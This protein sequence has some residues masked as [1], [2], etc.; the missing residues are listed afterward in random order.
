MRRVPRPA[1]PVPEAVSQHEGRPSGV[2]RH[3]ARPARAAGREEGV[4]PLGHPLRLSAGGQEERFPDRAGAPSRVRPAEGRAGARQP[5]RPALYGQAQCGG[6]RRVLPPLQAGQRAR[7]TEAVSGALFHVQPSG[8]HAQR[9]GDAGGLHE[10]DR[11]AS[12]SGAGLLSHAGHA[13]HGHVLHRSGSP[14]HAAGLRAARSRR[15]G[16]P[17]RADAVQQAPEPRAGGKSAAQGGPRGS[18]RLGQRLPD[19][20][21][22]RAWIWERRTEAGREARRSR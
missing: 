10:K 2:H 21:R 4:H 20:A 16:A 15:K 19:P 5:Q 18:H 11:P 7:G 6:L 13:V 8:L 17:A 1:V 3:P 12:R 9:R 22:G 14:G